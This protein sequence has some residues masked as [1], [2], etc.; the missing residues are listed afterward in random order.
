MLALKKSVPDPPASGDDFATTKAKWHAIKA[1]HDALT[2]LI[3]GLEVALGFAA[4][5]NDWQRV[6]ERLKALAEPHLELA[7]RKPDK[8]RAQHREAVEAEADMRPELRDA[9]ENWER[10][11]AKETSAIALSLQPKQRAIIFDRLIPAVEAISDSLIELEVLQAELQRRAPNPH[12]PYLPDVSFL[13]PGKLTD[14]GSPA[15]QWR[16]ELRRLGILK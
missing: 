11:K 10:A 13:L 8:V 3:L 6:P 9:W 12:S 2:D 4:K 7:T 14:W 15:S 16:R 5:P 1:R